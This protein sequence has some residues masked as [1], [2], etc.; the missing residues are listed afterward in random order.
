MMK[1]YRQKQELQAAK[2][3]QMKLKAERLQEEKRM[4]DEFKSKMAEK[5]A[6][7]ERLEQ[8]NA[9]KRRMREQEHKREIERLWQEKLAVYRVQREQEWEEK[10]LKQEQEFIQQEIIAREKER[11]L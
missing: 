2:D 10:R 5:F 3:Y 7:D 4:E 6:E 11:L 9:Q 8:M 1:K